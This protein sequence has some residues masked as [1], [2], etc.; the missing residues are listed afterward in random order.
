MTDNQDWK[1]DLES[2]G[3]SDG[4]SDSDSG[5]GDFSSLSTL[6]IS[7]V[8]MPISVLGIVAFLQESVITASF[9]AIGFTG[10]ALEALVAAFS[11]LGLLTVAGLGLIVGLTVVALLVA[12]V[13]R[14]AVGAVFF[15]L[16]FLYLGATYTIATLFLGGLPLLVGYVIASTMLIY[17]IFVVVAFLAGS[18]V[19]AIAG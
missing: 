11:V 10:L 5:S 1:F 14:S 18:A 7:T 2:L 16:G 4:D 17:L 12:L 15:L 6:G 13:K 9:A 8:L 19:I 3:E